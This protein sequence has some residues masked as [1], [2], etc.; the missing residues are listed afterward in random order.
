MPGISYRHYLGKETVLNLLALA[1]CYRYSLI[2]GI[3]ALSRHVEITV[4]EEV[5]GLKGAG[6]TLTR[7]VE[8]RD[9][10]QNHLLRILC[11]IAV[12]PPST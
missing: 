11:M 7:P 6:D 5:K 4:A 1:F 10:I 9:M 8:L 3:T 12:M 2:T